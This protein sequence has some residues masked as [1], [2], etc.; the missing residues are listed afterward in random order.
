MSYIVS[1]YHVVLSTYKRQNVIRQNQKKD[2][3]YYIWGIIKKHQCK[4]IRMN[5][6][7][8]HIHILLELHPSVAMRVTSPT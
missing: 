8:N 4:L 2:I 7:P 1:I 5:G 6:M 3:Y